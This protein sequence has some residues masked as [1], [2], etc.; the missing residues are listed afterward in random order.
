ME[1]FARR[2][3]SRTQ[4]FPEVVVGHEYGGATDDRY[5]G[6]DNQ[7]KSGTRTLAHNSYTFRNPVSSHVQ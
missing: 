2:L 7:A 4:N 6:L 3:E 5:V 1:R